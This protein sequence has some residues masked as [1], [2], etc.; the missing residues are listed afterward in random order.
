MIH[1]LIFVAEAMCWFMWIL[2]AILSAFLGYTAKNYKDIKP[3]VEDKEREACDRLSKYL[4]NLS[5]LFFIPSIILLPVCFFIWI[6]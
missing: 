6:W 2:L 1:H 3:D 4:G 5:N